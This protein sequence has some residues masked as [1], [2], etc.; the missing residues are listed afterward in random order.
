MSFHK[1][2]CY[3]IG[4]WNMINSFHNLQKTNYTHYYPVH[5]IIHCII[6]PFLTDDVGINILDI[7][8]GVKPIYIDDVV[9]SNI[10]NVY[11]FYKVYIKYSKQYIP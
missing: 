2:F 1:I 4:T 9:V 10:I 5:N 11:G 8:V 3:M 7:W 6:L